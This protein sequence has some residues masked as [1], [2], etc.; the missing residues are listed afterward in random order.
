MER[1]PVFPDQEREGR[2]KWFAAEHPGR[3]A[4]VALEHVEQFRP[5]VRHELSALGEDAITLWA[6]ERFARHG[7]S[8]MKALTVCQPWGTSIVLGTKPVENRVWRTN[9][10]G[11]L[12]IHAG[13]SRA[14]LNDAYSDD[15]LRLLLPPPDSLVYGAILGSVTVVDCVSLEALPR[16]LRDN[17]FVFGPFCW[18]LKNAVAFKTPI[19]FR[20]RQQ[21]FDVPDEIVRAA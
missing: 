17:P 19:P 5:I 13:M 12:L 16:E 18:I 7:S 2:L 15:R 14:W 9:F 1:D 20:G 21:L 10:R 8:V 6:W 11:E 3:C 4:L